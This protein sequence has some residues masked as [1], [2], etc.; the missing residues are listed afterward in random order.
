MDNQTSSVPASEHPHD[1]FRHC[2]GVVLI[3][4]AGLVFAGRR[5]GL[6][7]SWQMPQGGIDSGET[8]RQAAFRELHEETGVPMNK[9]KLLQESR[10]WHAYVIPD[11]MIKESWRGR[12][13]GQTQKW[14]LM[15]LC[16]P[17]SLIDLER[18][19]PE[20]D[21]WQWMEPAEIN[22]RI[23]AFKQPIYQAVIAEFLEKIS[24]N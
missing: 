8:P 6:P 15:Q 17:D 5:I 20:F 4:D 1:G 16:G 19:H 18:H 7:D 21:R 13:K 2:V 9:A 12:F 24:A 10:N 11:Q 23:V 14:F 22:Q 3:N